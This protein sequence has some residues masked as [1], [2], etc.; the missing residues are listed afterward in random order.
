MGFIC[1]AAAAQFNRHLVAKLAVEI[2]DAGDALQQIS[3]CLAAA[4]E[5]LKKR[6]YQPALA[7]ILIRP[8][9]FRTA[10]QKWNA[11][12]GPVL[13]DADQGR[14]DAFGGFFLNHNSERSGGIINIQGQHIARPH[15]DACVRFA[16]FVFGQDSGEKFNQAVKVIRG[17][18]T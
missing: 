2:G 17:G 6:S 8:H 3:S 4:V 16:G 14:S 11:G 13:G 12:V 15:A 18:I 9:R 5:L 10:D 1:A 7:K